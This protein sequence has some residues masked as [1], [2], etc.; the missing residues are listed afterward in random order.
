MVCSDNSYLFFV[1]HAIQ[2]HTFASTMHGI[3][4]GVL[5]ESASR[6]YALSAACDVVIHTLNPHI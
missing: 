4:L 2:R 6:I 5:N 1:S 3:W